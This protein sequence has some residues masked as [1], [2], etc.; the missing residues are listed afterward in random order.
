MIF[1]WRPKI[2]AATWTFYLNYIK[3]T[4]VRL[5]EKIRDVLRID[6]SLIKDP[7]KF[8]AEHPAVYLKPSLPRR[9]DKIFGKHALKLAH[10]FRPVRLS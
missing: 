8:A 1:C 3:K 7:Y 6:V 4:V 2:Q 10:R 5:H 9:F